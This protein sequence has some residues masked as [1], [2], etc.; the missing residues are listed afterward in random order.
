VRETT[1]RLRRRLRDV[2]QAHR[3]EVDDLLAERGPL[4]RGTFGSRARVCGKPGC[5]CTQGELHVSKYLS[6]SDGGAVRQV[7]VPA[8][9]EVRVAEGVARYRR[10][11]ERRVRLAELGKRQLELVDALGRS[12]L[13][14]F[15]PNDP[16]PPPKRR[17]RPPKHGGRHG[18]R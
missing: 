17:G 4:L 15:P 10:F 13:G 9:D 7:H 1:S 5:R 18:R 14:A 16:L 6:A 3:D 2:A 11:R 12:L 8:A